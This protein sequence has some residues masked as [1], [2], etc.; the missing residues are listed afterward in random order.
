MAS[1]IN[2]IWQHYGVIPQ[3]ANL[4]SYIIPLIMNKLDPHR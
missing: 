1:A 4:H 2:S 3:L